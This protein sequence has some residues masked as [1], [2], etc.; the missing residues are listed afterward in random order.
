MVEQQKVLVEELK[1]TKNESSIYLKRQALQRLPKFRGDPTDWPRFS[2][3]YRETNRAG[4][5]TN[6][7]NTTRL[8]E[9]LEGPAKS[10]VQSRLINP[11]SVN[12]AWGLLELTFGNSNVIYDRLI[13][14]LMAAKAP[15]DGNRTTFTEFSMKVSN[16]VSNVT[17]MHEEVKLKDSRLIRDLLLKLPLHLQEKW[18]D[19]SMDKDET[20]LIIFDTFLRNRLVK[21]LKLPV[22]AKDSSVATTS[23][24]RGGVHLQSPETAAESTNKP[25]LKCMLCSKMGHRIET[26]RDYLAMN[27]NA[28]W[29]KVK[30]LKL[31]FACLGKTY[32]RLRECRHSRGCGMNGCNKKHHKTLHPPSSVQ[33]SSTSNNSGSNLETNSERTRRTNSNASGN[34]SKDSERSSEGNFSIGGQRSLFMIL[35]VTLHSAEKSIDTFAFLDSGST[36]TLIDAE[37][38]NDLNLVGTPE[39]LSMI[40]AQGMVAKDNNSMIT[41][42][43]V[44]GATKSKRFDICEARTVRNLRLPKGF[45]NAAALQQRH[46]HLKGLPIATFDNAVPRIL[47]G[48]NNGSLLA[49]HNVIEKDENAPVAVKTR[50]GW[51]LFGRNPIQQ[52]SEEHGLSFVI[53]ED[54]E[55]TLDLH[56]L[57]KQFFTTESFGT[58]PIVNIQKSVEDQ[59]VQEILK[60]TLKPIPDQKR[61]QCGLLWKSNETNF[62]ES[63]QMAMNRLL[64]VEA[65]MKK[66][67]ELKDWYIKKIND[68]EAKGFCRKLTPEEM[69][70]E[71]KRL[72]YIP[73]FPVINPNK[74][75]IKRRLVFDAAAKVGRTSLNSELLTGPNCYANLVGM[76]FRAR[77]GK[78]CIAADI[79]EMFPQVRLPYD[80]AIGLR[81]LFRDDNYSKPPEI[82]IMLSLFFGPRCGPFIAQHVKNYNAEKFA[83]SNKEAVKAIQEQHFMDDYFDSYETKE[84]AIEIATQ[85]IKINLEGGFNTRNFVSNSPE[86]LKALP[87]AEKIV[88]DIAV[89]FTDNP[90]NK[91]EKILGMFWNVDQDTYGF[92]INANKINSDIWSLKRPPT[93]RELTR[94]TMSIF[95]PIGLL[96][97]I[98]IRPKV[99]IQKTW[100]ANI[101]WDEPITPIL[102]KEWASWLK[103]LKDIEQI[104]IERPYTSSLADV[105][106]VQ[107]HTFVDASAATYA[108]AIYFRMQY[109]GKIEVALVTAKSRVAPN[110]ALSIPKLELQAAVLGSRLAQSVEKEHRIKIDKKFYWSDS[111]NVLSWI[112]KADPQS[113][114]SFFAVRI[115][116]ILEL[117]NPTEWRKVP[118]AEN[119]ADDA[120]K[121]DH[122]ESYKTN[123]RWFIGP[124]FLK[125]DQSHWPAM[126]ELPKPTEQIS[127]IYLIRES[128]MSYTAVPVDKYSNYSKLLKVMAYV[129]KF[130]QGATQQIPGEIKRENLQKFKADKIMPQLNSEDI[131]IAEALIIGRAQF[132]TYP[133]E[134]IRLKNGNDISN[135]SPLWPLSPVIKEGVIRIDSR[136]KAAPGVDESVISPAILPNKHPVTDMIVNHYHR[137]FAHQFQEAVITAIRQ[138]FWIIHIRQAIL[139]V[140]SNCVP[141]RERRAKPVQNI[142]GGLPV[143]RLDWMTKPFNYVGIDLFGPFNVAVFRRRVKVW[144]MIFACMVT[145]AVHLEVV[146]SLST[147]A[148]ILN[149]RNF[150]NRHGPTRH[151]Y[152]DN[153]TNFHGAHNELLYE[154]TQMSSELA[155]ANEEYWIDWHFNPPAASNFGGAYERLIQSVRRAL[156][157]ILNDQSPQEDTLRSALIECENILNSRPLTH[158]PVNADDKEPLTP[159]HFLKHHANCLPAPGEFTE[160]DLNLRKQWRIAQQLANGFWNRWRQE[161]L[162]EL[163]RRSKWYAVKPNLNIGDIVFIVDNSCQRNDWKRAK[164]VNLYYGDDGVARVASVESNGKTYRR[165]INKLAKIDYSDDTHSLE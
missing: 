92:R 124:E 20:D 126:E 116:E 131:R 63:H 112:L 115:G 113:L 18:I 130:I 31:C 97:H 87:N 43:K 33:N 139:R 52:N 16:L 118:T 4:E 140:R 65:R 22:P 40:C 165:P 142:M 109:Q 73:H 159:N 9:A 94:V 114:K 72:W 95:D 161:Y 11:D 89:P 34:S 101:D 150:L 91:T 38:A 135:K 45:Q 23:G 61:Y 146:K 85:V 50:L 30:E 74:T 25:P 147:D 84:N 1:A 36:F 66:D 144:V 10:L 98:L 49:H 28:R 78:I 37:L 17:A 121:W 99:I 2:A 69:S 143:C 57:V 151:I 128:D 75:P 157:V 58:K 96:A 5:F 137:K 149:L 145:R 83:E 67:P 148:C 82:Y 134:F 125:K 154:L 44:S 122:V 77:E 162:P 71:P 105:M 88:K 160:R 141:C 64:N 55:E 103:R 158:V 24:A 70:I 86:V 54:E 21:I 163:A 104:N 102:C 107:M 6:I 46:P 127:G 129:C 26:C 56:E 138:K 59:R 106:E 14:D 152:C 79:E 47:I 80:E 136:I 53:G 62:P 29:E 119:V 7:E 39:P 19:Y 100:R 90:E 132:D 27:V 15:K 8:L 133:E 12:E 156:E 111:K 76:M 164:I 120:T 155:T 42:C 93:K 123:D 110:K 35:P 60:D 48:V 153:G 81:F 32:H 68:Y 108:A 3:I 13:A 51:C 41:S 117:T